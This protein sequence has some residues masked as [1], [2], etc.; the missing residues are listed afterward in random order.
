MPK[1]SENRIATEPPLVTLEPNRA[2]MTAVWP[3][4][5]LHEVAHVICPKCCAQCEW[6]RVVAQLM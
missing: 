3:Q 6:R 2:V 1:M 5:T 4:Y